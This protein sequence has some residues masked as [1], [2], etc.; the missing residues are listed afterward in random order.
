MYPTSQQDAN[1]EHRVSGVNYYKQI[2]DI[3]EKG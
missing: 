3:T 2:G 1:S